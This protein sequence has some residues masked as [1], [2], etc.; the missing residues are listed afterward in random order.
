MDKIIDFKCIINEAI[1]LSEEE[2]TIL[3]ITY[4]E[5]HSNKEMLIKAAK[6]MKDKT[7]S[8]FCELPFCHTLEAENM[9]GNVNYG[10]HLI[11]PRAGE[12]TI[13]LFNDLSNLPSFDFNKGRMRVVLEA[14][15]DLSDS[16]EVTLL[17]V[18]GPFTILNT[19]IDPKYIFKAI[20]KEPELAWQLFDKL[21]DDLLKYLEIA[22]EN[23]VKLISFADSLGGVEI[24]GPKL[25]ITYLDRFVYPFIKKALEIC[26]DKMVLIL[27]P[28]LTYALTSTNKAHFEDILFD[29]LLTYGEAL[30]SL[31]GNNVVMGER[32][33]QTQNSVLHA[34]MI[35]KIVLD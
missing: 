5:V 24:L 33:I 10:N 23:G 30:V 14:I 25:M 19:L 7:N 9:G 2:A 11:G 20:R 28:K 22:K 1:G 29:E 8:P 35:K 27:C 31:I 17:N 21:Q 16:N 4:P 26:D 15:K 12:Y 13:T 34:N 32:C 18:S 6:A 3:N